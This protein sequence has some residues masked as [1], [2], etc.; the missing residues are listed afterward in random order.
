[1]SQSALLIIDVQQSFQHRPFWQEDDL[2]AFQQALT[3]LI[4]G[5]RQRGAALVDVLHVSPQGPFSLASGHVQRLPFLTH[6]ADITVHK[7]VHN[8]LTESGLNAWL[9]DLGIFG[10]RSSQKRVPTAAV[11]MPSVSLRMSFIPMPITESTLSVILGST[12]AEIRL[13]ISSLMRATSSFPSFRKPENFSIE[14]TPKMPPFPAERSIIGFT[15]FSIIGMTFFSHPVYVP[16]QSFSMEIPQRPRLWRYYTPANAPREDGTIDLH[17]QRID[18]GEEVV[19]EHG[20]DVDDQR[21][22][23]HDAEHR[24]EGTQ[25]RAHDQAQFG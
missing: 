14:S 24:A 20:V 5:C 10:Q 17:V 11:T 9:R 16:G 6:Q 1:M 3:R 15:N 13:K 23:Q 18:G 7:H 2:P 21:Q 4:A 25:H 8:A 12:Q 22:Q 19:T